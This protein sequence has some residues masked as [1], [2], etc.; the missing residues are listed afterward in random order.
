LWQLKS[1]FLKSSI[2][3][4]ALPFDPGRVHSHGPA[5]VLGALFGAARFAP[6]AVLFSRRSPVPG[7]VGA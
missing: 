2:S 7:W 6:G 1:G 3:C 5:D 4:F